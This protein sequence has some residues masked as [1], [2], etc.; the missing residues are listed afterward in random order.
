M[1]K[2][3]EFYSDSEAVGPEILL[4]RPHAS[5][6]ISGLQIPRKP[7]RSSADD[8]FDLGVRL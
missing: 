3:N 8:D 6:K 2:F 5:S 1:T 7:Y 4:S